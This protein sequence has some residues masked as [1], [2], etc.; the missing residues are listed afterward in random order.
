MPDAPDATNDQPAPDGVEREPANPADPTYLQPPPGLHVRRPD[1]D[2]QPLIVELYARAAVV[3]GAGTTGR[4]ALRTDRDLAR[5]WTE[6][7]NDALV[8]EHNGAIVG[9]LEFHES[10]DPWTPELDLYAEGR[11]DPSAAGNGVGTFML[12]R[13]RDRADRA[14]A[15][16]P[17]LTTE[18][19]TTLVDPSPDVLR[20]FAN[21]GL[22]QQRHM[23]QL[24]I[25]IG[26]ATPVPVWPTG[27][28]PSAAGRVEVASLHA[29][30][31]ESFDDHHLGATDDLDGWQRVAI[32]AGRVQLAASLVALDDDGRPIGVALGRAGASG[33]PGLGVITDL[34]VVPAWR[35]RGLATALLRAS[36]ARFAELG[37][38]RVGLD[39]DDIT[40]DGAFRLYER[41]GMEV[42][43]HTVVLTTGPLRA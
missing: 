36:F 3:S 1:D 12:Q 23:L 26:P 22:V 10:Y 8:V 37:V 41:A 14:A 24:R 35:G 20:V 39:V 31:V 9:Y 33:D 16:N 27:T 40:L 28:R 18:L 13:A 32:D 29:A 38:D 6:R 25:D 17:Q 43:H 19:R 34:G 11:V 4:G 2:D 15:R 7:R 30:V 21:H 42:V 5:T